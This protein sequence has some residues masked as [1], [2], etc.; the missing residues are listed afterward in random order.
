VDHQVPPGHDLNLLS[1]PFPAAAL[2]RR[3]RMLLSPEAQLAQ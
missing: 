2:V 3:V 1:K